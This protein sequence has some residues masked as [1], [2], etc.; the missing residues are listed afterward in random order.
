M[1]RRY[2]TKAAK[3]AALRTQNH[4]CAECLHVMHSWDIDWDHIVPLALGGSNE[5]FN[6]QALHKVCHKIKSKDDIGKIRKADRQGK[7][8]R[9]EKKRRGQR[10]QSAP[11]QTRL[12]KRMDG[13]VEVR[14]CD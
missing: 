13:T 1:K 14:C 11:F 2:L 10:I 7:A 6:F 3:A 9:G 12:R 8:H 5:S 4:R